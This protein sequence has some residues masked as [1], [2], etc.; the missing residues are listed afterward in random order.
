MPRSSKLIHGVPVATVK[1][2]ARQGRFFQRL[3]V[4][5][6]TNSG[7]VARE[8]KVSSKT[9]RNWRELHEP[10]PR[11]IYNVLLN[12]YFDYA[13]HPSK[14]WTTFAVALNR[15]ALAARLAGFGE[16]CV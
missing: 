15:R 2:L 13:E 1:R 7:A 6:E 16:S 9:A 8:L 5:L 14:T 12:A 10:I 11:E 3:L 4:I